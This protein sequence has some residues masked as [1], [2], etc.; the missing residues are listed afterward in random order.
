[1]FP[2]AGGVKALAARAGKRGR[3]FAVKETDATWFSQANSSVPEFPPPLESVI[4]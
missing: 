4:L 3:H 1:M 2:Q